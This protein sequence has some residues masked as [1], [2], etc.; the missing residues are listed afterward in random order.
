VV[1]V[2][3]EVVSIDKLHQLIGHI[4]PE[5][6]KVLIKK[7]LVKGFKLDTSGE[8]PKLCNACEYGKAHRESVTK[9]C[10]VPKAAKIGDQVHLDI[11]GPSPVQTMGGREYYSTYTDN[12]SCFT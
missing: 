10:E 8:M 1:A 12:H 7:G 2:N 5:A 3:P 11:W 4:A 6:A 9:E